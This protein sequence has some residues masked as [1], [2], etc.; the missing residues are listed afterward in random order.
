MVVRLLKELQWT[1]IQP[2]KKQ[3]RE[4]PS[5]YLESRVLIIM[6]GVGSSGLNQTAGSSWGFPLLPPKEMFKI[7]HF[8]PPLL[9]SLRQSVCLCLS[10]SCFLSHS[11]S[12]SHSLG[13]HNSIIQ[14]DIQHDNLYDFSTTGVNIKI[15]N[16]ISNTIFHLNCC[17]RSEK[18]SSMFPF[19]KD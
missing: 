11:Y 14:Y 4:T 12:H 15:Y 3:K 7:R 1:P 17:I 19:D 6:C 10:L 16:A 9:I 5:L 13:T 2:L 18:T 8:Y